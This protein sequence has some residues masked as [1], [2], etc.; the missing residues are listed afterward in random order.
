[1][2]KPKKLAIDTEDCAVSW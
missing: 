2:Q 1:L